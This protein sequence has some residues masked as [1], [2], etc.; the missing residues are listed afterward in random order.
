MSK[1]NNEEKSKLTFFPNTSEEY[2]LLFQDMLN[3]Q[4]NENLGLYMG[5]SISHKRLNRA[6]V[7]FVVAKVR[8]RLAK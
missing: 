1:K 7:Q 2:K 6:Q 4:E 8:S 3:I 5:M